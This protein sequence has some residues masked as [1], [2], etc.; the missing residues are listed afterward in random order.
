MST[1]ALARAARG[2]IESALDAVGWPWARRLS[3]WIDV[4]VLVEEGGA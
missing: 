4:L 3:L 1:T 2:E